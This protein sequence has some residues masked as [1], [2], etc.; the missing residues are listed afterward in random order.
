MSRKCGRFKDS[1]GDSFY[2]Y[3]M[4]DVIQSFYVGGDADTYYPVELQARHAFNEPQHV[5][6]DLA[7]VSIFRGYS[8]TAP[9]TWNNS[10]H[11]GGLTLSFFWNGDTSWGGNGTGSSIKVICF[12]QTYCKM[13]Y[14]YSLSTQGMI[15]WLR[16]GNALYKIKS[17]RGLD[18]TP[19]VY[20]ED[21][22]DNNGTTFSPKTGTP[23]IDNR[24]LVTRLN[25]IYPVRFRLHECKFNE[26]SKSVWTELG[27]K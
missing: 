5:V 12:S 27:L 21:F 9:D 11:K 24:I 10:T 17:T 19:T 8:W 4:Q 22:T 26:S 15:V 14:N 20:L 25:E 6:Y 1:N 2:P 18:I 3:G 7:Q 23:T 16:G 13:V